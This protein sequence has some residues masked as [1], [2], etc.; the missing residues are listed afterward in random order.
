MLRSPRFWIMMSFLTPIIFYRLY[1]IIYFYKRKAQSN[2]DYISK[3]SYRSQVWKVHRVNMG[4]NPYY[5]KLSKKGRIKFISRVIHVL[6]QKK[7][8][9]REGQVVTIEK[10]VLIIS[11]LIQLTFGLDKYALPK[12]FGIALYPEVFFSKL[13]NVHVKGLTFAKGTILL[14]WFDTVKGFH[15]PSDNLNLV[16]HEWSHAFIIDHE[17]YEHRWLYSSLNTGIEKMKAFYEDYKSKDNQHPYLRKYAYV[18]HHEFFAVCVEHFFETP[19]K[20]A[21]AMPDVYTVLASLL[22][23]NPLNRNSDYSLV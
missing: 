16:L 11:G 14:S 9:G 23:Q 2:P 21:V 15:N 19:Q 1:G 6:Q 7:F 3:T 10:K 20:F 22:N 17:Y 18:N 8:V 12:F 4:L 13:M 5:K